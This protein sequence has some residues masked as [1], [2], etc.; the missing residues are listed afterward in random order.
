VTDQAT[1]KNRRS[2]VAQDQP[3]RGTGQFNFKVHCPAP[4]ECTLD[5][6]YDRRLASLSLP[7]SKKNKHSARTDTAGVELPAAKRRKLEST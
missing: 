6:E 4:A 1:E 7:V 5:F 3:E 2:E